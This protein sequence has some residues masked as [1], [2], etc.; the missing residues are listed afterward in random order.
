MSNDY[1]SGDDLRGE[2]DLSN[3]EVL[4]GEAARRRALE[5]REA[6]TVAWERLARARGAT[7]GTSGITPSQEETEAR[8]ALVAL[9]VPAP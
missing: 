4:R 3:E 2:Y 9:G 5:Q 7:L 1:V 8:L 6:L